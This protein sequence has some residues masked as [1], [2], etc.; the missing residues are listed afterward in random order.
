MTAIPD[1]PGDVAVKLASLV[2]H[3][4]EGIDTGHPF[5]AAAVKAL[6][7]DH[8]VLAWLDGFD[9]VLLPVRH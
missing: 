1:L 3:C 4:Q 2:V 8:G 9:P 7:S 5:D 6:A